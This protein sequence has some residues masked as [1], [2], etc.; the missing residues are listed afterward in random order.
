MEKGC[1]KKQ[2]LNLDL[3]DPC[4]RG[5]AVQVKERLEAGADPNIKNNKG[6]TAL[7]CTSSSGHLECLKLLIKHK[8]DLNIQDNWGIA[9]L[10]WASRNGH[11][12]CVELLVEAGADLN[13]QNR[14]GATALHMAS[15]W[16]RCECME[17]LLERGANINIQDKWGETALHWTLR[18]NHIK[19][20]KLLLR[21]GADPNLQNTHGKTV[22]DMA[23]GELK[24]VLKNWKTY[25]PPW[26]RYTT[27]KY[28]PVEF[29]K[30][31]F[32]WLSSSKLPKDLRYLVLPKLAEKWKLKNIYSL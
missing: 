7:Q 22:I 32:A 29:N 1:V 2:K 24:K 19:Y 4:K 21:Y 27:A 12:E 16:G 26:N 20:A 23:N 25:L 28:Y 9:A 10:Y 8:A 11:A 13:S 17:L 5:D 3:F 15:F 31:A 14:N 30:I 6:Y 18:A